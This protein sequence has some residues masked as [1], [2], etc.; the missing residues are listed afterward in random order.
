M[1]EE[2]P[3]KLNLTLDQKTKIEAHQEET[4]LKM[5]EKA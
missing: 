5:R 2:I 3:A 4:T 1:H